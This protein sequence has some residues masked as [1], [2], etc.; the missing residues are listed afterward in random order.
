MNISPVF[1]RDYMPE[2]CGNLEIYKL[3]EFVTKADNIDGGWIANLFLVKMVNIA[4]QNLRSLSISTFAC[5]T[6]VRINMIY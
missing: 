2:G 6:I 1:Y 3:L 5:Y 4:N